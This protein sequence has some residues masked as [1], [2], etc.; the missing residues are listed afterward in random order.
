MLRRG[1]VSAGGEPV[2]APDVAQGAGTLACNGHAMA[3]V[4]RV[5]AVTGEAAPEVVE[6][7]DHLEWLALQ[8]DR[9]HQRSGRL[10]ALVILDC[11]SRQNSV[12]TMAGSCCNHVIIAA[13]TAL[14]VRTS[15]FKRH[16]KLIITKEKHNLKRIDNGSLSINYLRAYI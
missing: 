8:D 4:S 6:L 9:L 13:R 5:V 14:F 10:R 2:V 15:N 1:A 11:G 3:H 16:R 12:A 7:V